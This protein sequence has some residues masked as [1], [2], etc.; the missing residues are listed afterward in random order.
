MRTESDIIIHDMETQAV[1]NIIE[2][3]AAE[4]NSESK[5]QVLPKQ[6]KKLTKLQ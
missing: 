5:E 1:I 6:L 3:R 4:V 2:D